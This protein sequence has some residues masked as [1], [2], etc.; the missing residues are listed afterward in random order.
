[1]SIPWAYRGVPGPAPDTL[2][3]WLLEMPPVLAVR[4]W[5]WVA[6]SPLDVPAWVWA[7]DSAAVAWAWAADSVPELPDRSWVWAPPWVAVRPTVSAPPVVPNARTVSPA[8]AL[9]PAP[10]RVRE[11][12]SGR[13]KLAP[14][15]P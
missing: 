15:P 9:E 2:W 11:R 4:L 8:G 14:V 3:L 13:L 5:T 1:M 12:R 6:D 7:A 10:T